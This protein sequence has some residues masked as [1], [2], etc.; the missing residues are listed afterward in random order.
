VAVIIGRA[1]KGVRAADA[2][3]HV[4]GYALAL[5]M[6]VRGTEDRSMRKSCDGFA[7]L[8]P[9]LVTADAIYDPAAIAFDLTVNGDLRQSADTG[10]LIR[11]IRELIEIC[12]RFY[13]LLP[14]D[15]IMTGTPAGVGPV[16]A[17]DR[18]TVRSALLGELS[19]DI[20]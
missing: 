14:G 10:L 3:D 16:V 8:G 7:V 17:G 19:V 18:V 6:T 9:A 20:Q 4:A 5:D 12:S 11:S 15:V 13:T 1:A 2:M